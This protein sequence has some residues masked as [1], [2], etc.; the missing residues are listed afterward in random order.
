MQEKPDQHAT[1]IPR[2]ICIWSQIIHI[3]RDQHIATFR[4]VV[5]KV[6]QDHCS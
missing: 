3:S 2:S 1:R 5:N 4:L 6:E